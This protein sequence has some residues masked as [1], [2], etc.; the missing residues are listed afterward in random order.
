VRTKPAPGLPTRQPRLSGSRIGGN[1]ASGNRD[2]ADG[3]GKAAVGVMAR[4]PGGQVPKV[5]S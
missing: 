5:T 2:L 3:A 1:P 4:W